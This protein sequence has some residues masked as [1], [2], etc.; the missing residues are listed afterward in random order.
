MLKH[1][2]LQRARV[3]LQRGKNYMGHVCHFEPQESAKRVENY[4][5]ASGSNYT[6]AA[7]K[8]T[9]RKTSRY[10]IS[11]TFLF[12]PRSLSHCSAFSG[13]PEGS[14]GKRKKKKRGR[15]CALIRAE[16][17]RRV[18]RKKYFASDA[19]KKAGPEVIFWTGK[20]GRDWRQKTDQTSVCAESCS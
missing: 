13:A 18:S 19:F 10:E 20:T 11:H 1:F 5:V 9:R 8:C 6:T 16:K 15:K 3:I 4:F 12:F 7:A 17:R 14:S 2:S